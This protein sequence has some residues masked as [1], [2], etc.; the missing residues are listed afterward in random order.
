M[1]LET[2]LTNAQGF[3]YMLDFLPIGNTLIFSK[4]WCG[5]VANF[6]LHSLHEEG[7]NQSGT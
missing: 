4:H 3:F 1:K 6:I 5:E 2:Y 7:K